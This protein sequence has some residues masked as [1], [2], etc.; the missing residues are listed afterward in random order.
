MRDKARER[1]REAV[2]QRGG[3][4]KDIWVITGKKCAFSSKKTN[5]KITLG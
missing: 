5:K 3:S 2:K 1:E 4:E